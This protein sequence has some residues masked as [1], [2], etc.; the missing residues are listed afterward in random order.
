[1]PATVIDESSGNQQHLD[2]GFALRAMLG[3]GMKVTKS[4][5]LGIGVQE[6]MFSQHPLTKLGGWM[7]ATQDFSQVAPLIYGDFI[8]Y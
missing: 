6:L 5:R 7:A 3:I 2:A 8:Y 4:V 1:V